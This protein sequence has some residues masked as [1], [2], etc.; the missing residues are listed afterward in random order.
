MPDIGSRCTATACHRGLWRA[1]ASLDELL[2]WE[3]IDRG[4][5]S[6]DVQDLL[7]RLDESRA[8]S[9]YLAV[10][11]RCGCV[12]SDVCSDLPCW[13]ACQVSWLAFV[14]LECKKPDFLELNFRAQ[15]RAANVFIYAFPTASASPHESWVPR[16]GRALYR[17]DAFAPAPALLRLPRKYG[18][19]KPLSVGMKV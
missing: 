19:G 10:P 18:A 15:K 4:R 12:H 5:K 2:L 17:P 8:L 6:R 13:D 14:G 1:L 9:V 16:P 11:V 7:R 3:R